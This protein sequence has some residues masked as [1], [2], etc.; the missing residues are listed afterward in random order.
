MVFLRIQIPVFRLRHNYDDKIR[1]ALASAAMRS[2]AT[3]KAVLQ[4]EQSPVP[5]DTGALRRSL[6]VGFDGDNTI[7]LTWGDPNVPYAAYVEEG[8]PAHPIVA[9]AGRVLSFI[10]HGRRVFFKSVQHP[11]TQPQPYAAE[12]A[13]IARDFVVDEVVTVLGEMGIAAER[14]ASTYGSRVYR[15]FIITTPE[16]VQP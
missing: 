7:T 8:T 14:P 16:G 3:I 6:Q 11:G 1:R 4:S 15:Q 9:R 10:W 5:A 12:S 13:A 2:A